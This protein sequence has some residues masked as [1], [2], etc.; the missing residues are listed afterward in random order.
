MS[1]P[2]FARS[3]LLLPCLTL[4]GACQSLYPSSSG[5]PETVQP[6]EPV[7][8]LQE[9]CVN[10]VTEDSTAAASIAEPN[11]VNS[12]IA[13]SP[14]QP[15][16]TNLWHR[17]SSNLQ[18]RHGDHPRVIKY[19]EQ[20]A[21]NPH[22]VE[23]WTADSAPFLYFLVEE[24]T[25]RDMPLELALIPIVE[26]NFNP[27][28]HSYSQAAGLWQFMPATAGR[29][30]LPMDEWY[31]GRRDV[32]SSTRAAL[33]YYEYLARKFDGDWLLALAA[34][35]A[36]EGRVQRA[37]KANRKAGK[38]TDFFALKLPKETMA[39]VPK[40][41]ALADIVR[42]ASLYQ[43]ELPM[44]GDA[45]FFEPVKVTG[46]LDLVKA[47]KLAN[48]E[49]EL[50]LMLNPG[51]NRLVIPKG[52]AATLLLPVGKRS[53]FEERLA[54]TP[55]AE[56]VELAYH[57]IAAGD[58]LSVIAQKYGVSVTEIKAANGLKSNLIRQG[59]VLQIP[60][61]AKVD[62]S[63]KA[64]LAQLSKQQRKSKR[65]KYRVKSGDSF[66]TISRKLGVNMSKLAS[67]NG[68]SLKSYL[69]P[70]QLLTVYR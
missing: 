51:F 29:F 35:N 3:L 44:I 54:S 61:V 1:Q 39:Y 5:T 58:S 11:E 32:Q 57:Q 26:S 15:E 53:L 23:K 12:S 27:I 56:R 19:R 37:V 17:V 46:S 59:K 24:I 33:D 7:A 34:F 25:A 48:I 52:R 70:G 50:F 42:D 69:R 47:A 4:L 14:A 60:L 36:G 66:W 38:P 64:F 31:D 41:M 65:I 43:V 40:I 49:T 21:R 67:W 28:A 16:T 9:P 22:H 8:V 30:K 13:P 68:L 63:G 6:V 45:P 10:C 20:F 2:T 18:L 62:D 55:E